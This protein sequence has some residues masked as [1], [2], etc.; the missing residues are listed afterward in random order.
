MQL[1]QSQHADS[2]KLL[3]RPRSQQSSERLRDIVDVEESRVVY[4]FHE[5]AG[6]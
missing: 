5:L 4:Q 6:H 1:E 3:G 2:A